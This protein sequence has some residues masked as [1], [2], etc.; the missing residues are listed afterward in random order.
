MKPLALALTTGLLLSVGT[1]SALELNEHFTIEGF[2]DLYFQ[3]QDRDGDP[4]FNSPDT[5]ERVASDSD[6]GLSQIE[7]SFQANY[8]AWSAQL[9]IDYE[10]A[11]SSDGSQTGEVEQLFASYQFEYGGAL[12]LGRFGSML[13][14]EDFEPTGLYQYSFAYELM[15]LDF[16]LLPDYGQGIKYTYLGDQHFF[17]VAL[18]DSISNQNEG[19][20]EDSWGIE[21]GAAYYTAHGI[22]FSS[23]GPGNRIPPPIA[24]TRI[25]TN[26]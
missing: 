19:S 25:P 13:G 5:D 6:Y 22:N 26:G 4:V 12:T 2:V 3:H 23:A 1:A 17:G 16:T 9:D 11:N 18:L 21:L 7:L 15:G 20:L 14:F 8:N 10:E 24:A